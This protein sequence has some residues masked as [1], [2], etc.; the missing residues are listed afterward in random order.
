MI[1]DVVVLL[2]L[3]VLNGVFAMSELAIASSRKTR[4][5]QWAEE[6]NR[7][8][9]AALAVT[10]TPWRRSSCQRSRNLHSRYHRTG[11]RLPR[12]GRFRCRRHRFADLRWL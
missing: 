6:G 5:Q 9:A 10:H 2:L 8:A 11:A 1:L 3:L 4:L 7:R 12:P